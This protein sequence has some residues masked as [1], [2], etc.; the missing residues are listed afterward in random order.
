MVFFLR[1]HHH[2]R[3]EFVQQR[4]EEERECLNFIEEEGFPREGGVLERG[5][6]LM[7]VV[8]AK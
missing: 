5:R 3:D 1:R 4:V 8:V 2:R 7:D 6:V